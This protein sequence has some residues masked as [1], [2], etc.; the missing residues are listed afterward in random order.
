[1][2]RILKPYLRHS[3]FSTTPIASDK[4]QVFDSDCYHHLTVLFI[5]WQSS[6]GLASTIT[7]SGAIH[8]VFDF[9]WKQVRLSASRPRCITW[10]MHVFAFGQLF[11]R[12]FGSG[13]GVHE[14]DDNKRP[15]WLSASRGKKIPFPQQMENILLMACFSSVMTQYEMMGRG[16]LDDRNC[17]SLTTPFSELCLEQTR[18][19]LWKQ[20]ELHNNFLSPF[21]W[22]LPWMHD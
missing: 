17:P 7:Q 3:A 11:C 13:S 15:P 19:W 22:L 16:Q 20:T 9:R 21:Q 5:S 2:S 10:S 12:G 1:M 6:S 8:G 4:T 18:D 14:N